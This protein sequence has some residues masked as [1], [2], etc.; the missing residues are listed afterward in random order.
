MI[1]RSAGLLKDLSRRFYR[2]A[3]EVAQEKVNNVRKDIASEK[4]KASEDEAIPVSVSSDVI[5]K[6]EESISINE[7]L[8]RD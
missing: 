6:G 3:K 4:T 8:A 5:L 7:R 2:K 1:K